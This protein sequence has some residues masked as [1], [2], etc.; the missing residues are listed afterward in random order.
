MREV[1]SLEYVLQVLQALHCQ[2]VAE[3]RRLE[4]VFD[5]SN[6]EMHLMLALLAV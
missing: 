1:G 3:V 5:Q 6:H 2:L 4:R